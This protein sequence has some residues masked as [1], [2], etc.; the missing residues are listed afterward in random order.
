MFIGACLSLAGCANLKPSQG[1]VLNLTHVHPFGATRIAFAPDSRRVASGGFGGEVIVWQVPDGR[2][3]ARLDGHTAAV[4]GLA[5]PDG[6]HL[7][8][9]AEDGRVIVWDLATRRRLHAVQAPPVTTMAWDGRRRVVVTGHADGRV[10]LRRLR[11]LSLIHALKLSSRVLSVA[12]RPGTGEIA[13]SAD[14]GTV[15]LLSKDLKPLR[16]LARPPRRALAL[17]FSPDGR[18]LAAGAWFRVLVW[19]LGNGRLSVLKTEHTGAII[20][21]DYTPDG[22]RLVSLGRHTD[23]NIRLRRLAGNR[24]E[25]RLAPHEYCG[26]QIRISPD[27]RWVGSVSE[28]ESLRLYDLREPYRPKWR[29]KNQGG[30]GE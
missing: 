13:V 8:S 23:A 24:L 9:A 3:L 26:W 25:R 29:W 18:Q 7:L 30:D 17:R 12:V 2:R 19:D 16:T 20:S 14:D 28:D 22:R 4:R 21:I 5:W 11:D 10:Q 6:R 1:P 15:R 27:G